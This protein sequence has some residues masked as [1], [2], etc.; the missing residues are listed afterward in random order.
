MLSLSHILEEEP[1]HLV[2]ITLLPLVENMTLGKSLWMCFPYEMEEMRLSLPGQ[3]G[4]I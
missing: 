4:G 1:G 2:L 3:I